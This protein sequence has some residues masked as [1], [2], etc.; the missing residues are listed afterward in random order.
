M[1]AVL[2]SKT[3]ALQFEWRAKRARGVTGRRELFAKLA[4]ELAVNVTD[5]DALMQEIKS[6][7]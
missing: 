6:L 1:S 5:H 7:S 2:Y 3:V 4:N